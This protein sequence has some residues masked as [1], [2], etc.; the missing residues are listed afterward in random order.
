L[1]KITQPIRNLT[2]LL[3]PL[4]AFVGLQAQADSHEAPPPPGALET[5]FCTYNDGK[6]RGDLDAA[7][8]YYLKQADKAGITPPPAYL[9][10]LN[11]GTSP[12]DIV[13]LNAHESMAAFAAADDA[14]LGSPE[15]AAAQTRFDS[16]GD[17]TP[18][19]GLVSQIYT[20]DPGPK[21]DG[22]TA[23]A[24]YACSF[25]KGIGPD[26]MGDL[27][28]HIA[29]VNAGMGD[30]SAAAVF[31][32]VPQNA[33]PDVVLLAVG[34]GTSGWNRHLEALGASEAGQGLLRHFN[35]IL[36]CEMNLWRVEQ[37]VGA[38]G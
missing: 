15:L 12:A 19:L 5:F 34:E 18:V 4:V 16:V 31:Q 38:E 17:C 27:A 1:K 10:T 22:R 11:K 14:G 7:T 9:W 2:Y 29:S 36:E 26:A 24:S 20:A 25:R 37:I 3:F 23:V 33:G 32:V 6:D 28:G 21:Y 8:S 30:D 35:T 13:W